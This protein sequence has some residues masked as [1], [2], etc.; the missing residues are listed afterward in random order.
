L[1]NSQPAVPNSRTRQGETPLKGVALLVVATVL[2]SVSDVMAKALTQ[3]LPVI[4]VVWLRYVAFV[5][6]AVWLDV[7]AGPGRFRVRWPGL[8][9]VRGLGLVGSAIVFVMAL[10]RMPLAETAAISYV[11]PALITILS[12]PVL[13]EKVG[14]AR[15]A[16]VVAGLIGVLLV[17]R[18]GTS[19]FQLAALLPV[20]SATCWSVASVVTRKIAPF[21][22]ATTTLLWSAVI[23]LIVLCLLMP[24]V[25]VWP[26]P[27]QWALGLALGVIA[28]AG[29]YLIVLAYR[30]AAASL[31]APFSYL[32]LIWS[33]VLGWL[34]FSAWPDRW[35]LLGAA[36]IVASG[37]V[38]AG[39]ERSGRRR[40][41]EAEPGRDQEAL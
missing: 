2:F 12:V 21:E 13:G 16:A 31:L 4:E 14:W 33:T 39:R 11:S 29:Q 36:I 6:L 38:M 35:T 30:H 19:A 28:S 10:Q 24:A 41:P 32:Q 27:G 17:M 20:A 9:L 34:V 7:R 40:E 15:A 25:A 22:R 3:S 8:Q 26:T 37:L 23:G 18:P 5:G 1:K